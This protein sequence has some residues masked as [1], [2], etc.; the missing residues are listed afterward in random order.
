MINKVK[1]L[2]FLLLLCNT[3]SHIQSFETIND[4]DNWKYRVEWQGGYAYLPTLDLFNYITTINDD[5][6][7]VRK[8]RITGLF[9]NGACKDLRI[10]IHADKKYLCSAPNGYDLDSGEF[11]M[12]FDALH[13]YL[14][15]AILCNDFTKEERIGLIT[16]A[17]ESGCNPYMR[18]SYAGIGRTNSLLGNSSKLFYGEPPISKFP[19]IEHIVN[20]QDPQFLQSMISSGMPLDIPLNNHVEPLK[21]RSRERIKNAQFESLIYY[22]KTLPMIQTLGGT[23][24]PE[25]IELGSSE[26]RAQLFRNIAEPG[27]SPELV[28]F[29]TRAGCSYPQAQTGLLTPLEHMAMWQRLYADVQCLPE[30]EPKVKAFLKLV[31][32]PEELE[33]AKE[34]SQNHYTDKAMHDVFVALVQGREKELAQENTENPN[35]RRRRLF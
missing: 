28:D 29:Y 22:A 31:F 16:S 10:D 33:S 25:N 2:F 24:C 32:D 35:K 26:Q 9:E 6:P 1:K 13:H 20:S 11:P 30:F 34:L 19:V 8:E 12:P 18:F 27:Y 14:I 17:V 15:A 5:V 21:R 23:V 3:L 7:E 4:G